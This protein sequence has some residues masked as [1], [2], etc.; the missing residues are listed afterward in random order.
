[1]KW[2]VCRKPAAFTGMHS[3]LKGPEYICTKHW[4]KEEKPNE[5]NV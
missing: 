3:I 1:M 5:R 4:D 2:G